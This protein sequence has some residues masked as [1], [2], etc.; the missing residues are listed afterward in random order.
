MRAVVS[1]DNV[2]PRKSGHDN[3]HRWSAIASGV[4]VYSGDELSDRTILKVRNA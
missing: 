2:E 4:P 3:A 1:I